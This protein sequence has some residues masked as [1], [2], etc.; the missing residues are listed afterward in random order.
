MTENVSRT[1][2]VQGGSHPSKS[3]WSMKQIVCHSTLQVILFALIMC[4]GIVGLVLAD[5]QAGVDAYEQGD[6]EIALKEWKPLAES[7]DSKAQFR[8]GVMY[9]KGVGVAQDYGEAFKWF[10]KAAEQR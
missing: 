5:Y 10:Q 4:L 3:H 9:D 7:G 6:Y 1:E 2:T 8:L